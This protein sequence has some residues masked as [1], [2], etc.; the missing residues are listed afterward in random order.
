MG[1]SA[2]LCVGSLATSSWSGGSEGGDEL[3]GAQGLV[4]AAAA[5]GWAASGVP[6]SAG[7]GV[8]GFARWCGGGAR[9]GPE[10]MAYASA[11]A[12]VP[13][14]VLM[15]LATNQACTII[16]NPL[17]ATENTLLYLYL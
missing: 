11:K 2:A 16:F 15:P 1:A 13:G 9:A 7:G 12:S 3:C 8:F 4:G 6:G 10:I 5:S 14:Y 17:R